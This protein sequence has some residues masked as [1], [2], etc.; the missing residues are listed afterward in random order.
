MY[1][2]QGLQGWFCLDDDKDGLVNS[3]EAQLGTDPLLADTDGDGLVDGNDGFVVIGSIPGGVDT[4][5]DGFVDGEQVF[6]TDPLLADSDGDRLDD[7]LEAADNSA[8]PLDAN[9]WPALADGD[10]APQGAPDGLINAGDILV[11]TRITL[12][13][14]SATALELAHGDLYPPGAPDG[15]INLQDLILLR[16]IP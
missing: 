2:R 5:G 4:N 13:L 9:S 3:L 1:K 6:A 10:I 15:I 16:K 8:D 12:G 7:G 11:A 14:E